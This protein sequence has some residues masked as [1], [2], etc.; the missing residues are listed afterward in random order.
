VTARSFLRC[1]RR[2][3]R[4]R[5]S[6]TDPSEA[7]GINFEIPPVSQGSPSEDRGLGDMLSREIPRALPIER[8]HPAGTQAVGVG[9]RG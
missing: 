8:I 2:A 7:A 1:K 6:M 4:A 5:Q 9:D 3:L